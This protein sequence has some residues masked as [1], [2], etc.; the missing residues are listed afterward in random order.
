MPQTPGGGVQGALIIYSLTSRESFINASKYID[1]VRGA[2][3][4]TGYRPWAL[5]LVSNKLDCGKEAREVSITEGEELASS[6]GI[7]FLEISAKTG[8][9]V[10]EAFCGLV[11]EMWK[12]DNPESKWDLGGGNA[13]RE[14]E[15]GKGVV[16]WLKKT[17]RK[18]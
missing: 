18:T 17:L 4:E 1:H 6:L 9:N 7:G 5:F 3:T 2:S 14:T 11:R 10:D 12:L 15:D 13:R 16:G 8:E